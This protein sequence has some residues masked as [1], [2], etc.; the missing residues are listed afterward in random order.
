MKNNSFLTPHPSYARRV[1][2]VFSIF[3]VLFII[4]LALFTYIIFMDRIDVS[5]QKSHEQAE[6]TM[7]STVILSQNAMEMYDSK[8]DYLLEDRLQQFR[9]AYEVAGSR[10]ET[11][12]LEDL[13]HSMSEGSKGQFDLF[14]FNQSGYIEYATYKPDLYRNFSEFPEFAATLKKIRE[15]NEIQV[16]PWIRYYANSSEYWKYGFIPTNDHKYILEVGYRNPD[17]IST[18][19]E[20][21]KKYKNLSAEALNESGVI[22]AVVYD[23]VHRKQKYLDSTTGVNTSPGGDIYS[24]RWLDKTLNETFLKRTPNIDYYLNNYLISVQYINFSSLQGPSKE[25]MNS[26]SLM[27]FPLNQRNTTIF[28]YQIIFCIL[29]LI[30]LAFGYFLGK[31]LAGHICRPIEIMTRDVQAMSESSWDY[32]VRDTG[33]AETEYLRNAINRLVQQLNTCVE[34]TEDQKKELEQELILRNRAETLLKLTVRRLIQLSQITRHDI[35]NQL[36]V[37][38]LRID[39][40]EENNDCIDKEDLIKKIQGTLSQIHALINYTSEYEKIGQTEPTWIS[41][42]D[43]VKRGVDTFLETV[44]ITVDITD[45]EMLADILMEKVFY[46]LVDNTIRHGISA[47]QITITF[48]ENEGTGQIIYSDN[49]RGIDE[50]KKETIF[51]YGYGAGTGIGLFFIREVIESNGMLIRETGKSGEGARFEIMIPKNYWR[52]RSE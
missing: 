31:S 41:L 44:S 27:I 8:Y 48:V 26:V 9:N 25:E 34:E 30:A 14:I 17:V 5:Y 49:G 32:M 16:D 47:D 24:S 10:V 21:L 3:M 35:L 36:N 52:C 22:Y 43:V 38:I 12:D 23:K 7:A 6:E 50:D 11:I 45:I 39:L 15:G 20:V 37:L 19:Q 1:S 33:I 29:T 46:N 42:P 2:I 4:L 28:Q 51:K 18:R 40:L 13:K